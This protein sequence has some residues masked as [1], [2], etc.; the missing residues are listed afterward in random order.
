MKSIFSI[1]KFV[2]IFNNKK[3]RKKLDKIILNF[4][5]LENNMKMECNQNNDEYVNLEITLFL[6]RLYLL[7]I[8]VKDT[9][10]L[11]KT[12][13]KFYINLSYKKA[14]KNHKLIYP[15]YWEFYYNVCSKSNI[16]KRRIETLAAL[17][18]AVNKKEVK[19]LLNE[20]KIFNKN[21]INDIMNIVEE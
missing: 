3:Y 4:F 17:F 11:F 12:S 15:C 18:G 6:D 13:K 5:G 10:S 9:K 7:K 2:K 21:E 14:Q 8:I 19:M 20:L 1:E 16:R